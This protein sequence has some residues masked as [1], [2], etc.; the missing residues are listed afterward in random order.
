LPTTNT[1]IVDVD[2]VGI[3]NHHQPVIM[4]VTIITIITTAI[5][6]T[7]PAYGTNHHPY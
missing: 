1:P 6:N 5:T 3:T 7:S 4:L 2:V